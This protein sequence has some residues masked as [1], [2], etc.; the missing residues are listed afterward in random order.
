[1]R[2]AG[3]YTH[4]VH[5]KEKILLYIYVTQVGLERTHL[6]LGGG[7]TLVSHDC[8]GLDLWAGNFC[9]GHWICILVILTAFDGI[10][11]YVSFLYSLIIDS[12]A[13]TYAHILFHFVSHFG[14]R[15]L[16]LC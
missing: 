11:G 13:P 9:P 3:L 6:H 14:L 15:V 10:T 12:L 7:G 8:P 4:A 1:M 2:P 5:S 16:L